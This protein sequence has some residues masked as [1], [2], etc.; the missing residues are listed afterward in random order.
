MPRGLTKKAHRYKRGGSH[1]KVEAEITAVPPQA[2][3]HLWLP[4]AGKGEKDLPLMASEGPRPCQHPDSGLKPSEL[5]VAR[6]NKFLL[7]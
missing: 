5:I 3:E 6:D 2:K 1:L 7:F 4:E